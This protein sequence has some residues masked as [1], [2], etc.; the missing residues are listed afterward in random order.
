MKISK[1]S[2]NAKTHK[3]QSESKSDQMLVDEEEFLS[4]K[5]NQINTFL[6]ESD[7]EEIIFQWGFDEILPT[8]NPEKYF[9]SN[10]IKKEDKNSGPCLTKNSNFLEMFNKNEIQ[11]YS[12]FNHTFG[13]P[14]ILTE[15]NR[16][17]FLEEC[18]QIKAEI[19]E[20]NNCRQE[21]EEIPNFEVTVTS[22]NNEHKNNQKIISEVMKR[23]DLIKS[24]SE[25]II[26]P[27]SEIHYSDP[28]LIDYYLCDFLELDKKKKRPLTGK[29]IDDGN[30]VPPLPSEIIEKFRKERNNFSLRFHYNSSPYSIS[31]KIFGY[32]FS[33]KC[34]KLSIDQYYTVSDV[35][36]LPF[37]KVRE[38]VC[39]AILM[40]LY[41][42]IKKWIDL[43]KL[44]NY[45]I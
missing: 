40:L 6:S 31:N 45:K 20:N 37:G 22:N 21:L 35:E 10:F 36:K 7:G 29:Q 15:D 32:C 39:Q 4:L 5:N 24:K 34:E 12:E 26:R 18:D 19:L 33:V 9:Q 17:M 30:Y 23:I 13:I 44:L 41:P 11:T 8:E 28:V 42:N 16:K 25:K 3:D 14:T 38:Y 1:I 27:Y 2:I 43:L